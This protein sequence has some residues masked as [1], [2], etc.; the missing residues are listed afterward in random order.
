MWLA[1]LV[2]R[3]VPVPRAWQRRGKYTDR[4][5]MPPL[6]EAT[7]ERLRHVSIFDGLSMKIMDLKILMRIMDSS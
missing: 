7:E 1:V 5:D 3:E 4:P 2:P 6:E